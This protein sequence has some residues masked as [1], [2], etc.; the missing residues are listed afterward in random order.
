IHGRAVAGAVLVDGAGQV[1]LLD[2][3][4]L[5]DGGVVGGGGLED[6]RDAAQRAVLVDGRAVRVAGLVDVERRVERD[7]QGGGRI[8]ASGL[9]DRRDVEA[10]GALRERRRLRRPG[11]VDLGRAA[12]HAAEA[13]LGL[14]D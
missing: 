4:A 1:V 7:L 3:R 6:R 5:V 11:L 12:D 10:A 14:R 8:A 9:L 13:V 2:R